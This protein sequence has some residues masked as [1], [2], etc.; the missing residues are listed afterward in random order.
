M[1]EN[2][3]LFS[4]ALVCFISASIYPLAS[5]AFVVGFV[6]SGFDKVQVFIIASIF[7]TLGSVST[8]ILGLFGSKLILE[9]F[10]HKSLE[11]I[12]N[13]RLNFKK[14]AALFAFLSFLPIF[15]DLFVLALALLRYPLLRAIF[16]I[17][18][19]K[20]FR[21]FLLIFWL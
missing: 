21:Y 5:E 1:L 7:N 15:G 18:L 4:L 10:F 2:L 9:K 6:L 17:F 8:Y 20:A 3:S 13:S 12:K 19:G 14:Y 11:R 16:F